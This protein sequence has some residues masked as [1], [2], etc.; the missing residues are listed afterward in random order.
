P[1][2]TL[3]RRLQGGGLILLWAVPISDAQLGE[4]NK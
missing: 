2:E 1:S 4:P 3:H